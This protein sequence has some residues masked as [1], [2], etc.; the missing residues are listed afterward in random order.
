M[1]NK[2]I[3]FIGVGT[4]LI[5]VVAGIMFYLK[6][7]QIINNASKNTTDSIDM[8]INTDDGDEK[9]DWSN[10]QDTEYIL[11]QSIT[12][13]DEGIYNLTGTISDGLIKVNTEGNVKL[14]LNNVNITNS[15]GPAIYIENASDVVI[16][17]SDG[18]KNYLEDGSNYLGYETDEIGTIFSHDDITFQGSGSLEV[19]SNNEDAIV[20]KDDLKIVD[21]TYIITSKDDGIRGKDSVYIQNGIF[22]INSAGDGIKSTNDTETEKG[23]ILIENGTFNINSTLDGIESQTKL[24]IKNGTFNITTGSGSENSSLSSNWG[25]WGSASSISSDSAKGLK[26]GDNLVIENGT[27]NFNTSDDS[28]HC[29]NY[30]GIKSGTINISSGDDGI[31]ADEELIIDGGNITISKSY[32]GLEAAKI[33]INNGTI[34]VIASDDG[35]NVAGGNDL[36]ATGRPGQNNYSSSSNN[37][38]TI[39]G[40]NIYVDA[41]GDGIDV[42]GSAYI[43]GGDIKVD[44]PTNSG[45]GAL[46]YDSIFEITGG[47]LIAGGASGM[48]QGCSSSSS[49]YNLTITFNSS[50][51]SGDVI[52]IVDSSNNEIISYQSSKSYSSLVIASPKLQ[53]G[54]TYTVKVNGEEYKSFTI[55]SITTTI[56]NNNNMGGAPVGPGGQRR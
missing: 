51:S 12:I 7:N 47:T 29:N 4:F 3:F 44:G 10:Y 18:S 27:F 34:N 25:R 26:S 17:L 36:S 30:V 32:E 46:D 21:G 38:L 23:Y 15:K 54:S 40:G 6:N 11:T 43:T 33:T 41:A 22:T 16:E 45:N 37:I 8:N 28:I 2:K 55:S 20:S 39:N 50:Y 31:H 24:F 48:L 56:G 35:I 52:T 5:I 19:V 42:N 1:K 14:V 13:T 9:I 49:I 53:K